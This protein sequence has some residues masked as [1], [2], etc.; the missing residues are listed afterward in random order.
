VTSSNAFNKDL[1][2]RV[3]GKKEDTIVEVLDGYQ[4]L[5]KEEVDNIN[6]NKL[7]PQ[8]IPVELK[9]GE[10]QMVKSE[11]VF[12]CSKAEILWMSDLAV[13]LQD[14]LQGEK[15]DLLVMMNCNMQLFE[16]GFLLREAVKVLI[17]SETKMWVYGYDYKN[18]LDRLSSQP[19]ISN[20]LLAKE[21]VEGYVTMHQNLGHQ[22]YL[23]TNIVIANSLHKYESLKDILQETTAYLLA[24]WEQVKPVILNLRNNY[25]FS[26][27]GR[28]VLFLLDIKLWV[29]TLFQIPEIAMPNKHR[30]Q[31]FIDDVEKTVLAK[32]IGAEFT[33]Q[34]KVGPPFYGASVAGLFFPL[35]D[36]F[37]QPRRYIWCEYFSGQRSSSFRAATL[38][39]EFIRKLI[40]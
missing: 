14:V 33:N 10:Y 26:V 40:T 22:K 7:A 6:E 12:D 32:H 37:S 30:Y 11:E 18:I 5:S 25:F 15:I 21:I 28:E 29:D 35:S 8:I 31:D 9:F 16:N 39:D 24:N 2:Y 27:S 38:W 23:D 34:D 19:A 36:R 13:F 1:S 4:Y 3:R 20:E 17:G